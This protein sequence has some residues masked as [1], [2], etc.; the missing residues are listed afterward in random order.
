MNRTTDFGRPRGGRGPQLND[1]TFE[2]RSSTKDAVKPEKFTSIAWAPDPFSSIELWCYRTAKKEP[3]GGDSCETYDRIVADPHQVCAAWID[4]VP[5]ADQF[6]PP[7]GYAPD[8]VATIDELKLYASSRFQA[9]YGLGTDQVSNWN[10]A[11]SRPWQAPSGSQ[12]VKVEHNHVY[13]LRQDD[14]TNYPAPRIVG[15]VWVPADFEGKPTGREI[16]LLYRKD[17]PGGFY[18]P[19]STAD[20]ESSPT[21]KARFRFEQYDPV[22]LGEWTTDAYAS[23]IQAFIDHAM[24][25]AGSPVVDASELTVH[26]FRVLSLA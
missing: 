22:F 6:V 10:V 3:G 1:G 7:P 13:T 24:A 20:G 19:G 15:W 21:D 18:V 25:Y 12:A 16:W 26:D 4:Q 23:T 8:S 11:V 17:Q 5:A 14:Q 9:H 2:G